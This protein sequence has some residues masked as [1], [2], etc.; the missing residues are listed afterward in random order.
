MT[1]NQKTALLWVALIAVALSIYFLVGR[2]GDAPTPSDFSEFVRAARDGEVVQVTYR[3]ETIEYTTEDGSSRVTTGPSPDPDLAADLA[4]SGVTVRFESPPWSVG[5]T[6]TLVAAG[7]VLLGLLALAWVIFTSRGR[8]PR[9]DFTKSRHRLRASQDAVRLDHVIGATEAIRVLRR[10]IRIFKSS[11]ARAAS[12]VGAKVR[13]TLLVGRPGVGKT[14]LAR[15]LANEAGVPFFAHSASEFVEMFVGVGAARVGDMF[16][17]AQAHAPC[18]VFIDEIDAVGRHRGDGSGW[19]NDEREQTLNQLLDKLDGFEPHMGVLVLAATNRP[20]VL[21]EALLRPGRF[22]HRVEVHGPR[23]DLERAQ[24]LEGALRGREVDDDV[25][26]EAVAR[27]AD[28]L[29]GAELVEVVEHAADLAFD[30]AAETPPEAAP[31]RSI[32]QPRPPDPGPPAP[33]GEK[34]ATTVPEEPPREP[35]PA[36]IQ[37]EHLEIGLAHVRRQKA[38]DPRP[39]EPRFTIT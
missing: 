18:V 37:Q 25:D 29:S 16:R 24:L 34:P 35:P 17:N 1:Q 36:V 23:T 38:R 11:H 32:F 15:A 9:T 39:D 13:H 6:V 7:L 12:A 21:D 4:R 8:E 14:M 26:V 31:K 28:G 22:S 30:E 3:G 5:D 33:V 19:G 20:D 10:T 2:G 27:A